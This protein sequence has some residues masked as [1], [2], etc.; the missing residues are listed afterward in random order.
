M[1]ILLRVS[2][3]LIHCYAWPGADWVE[4]VKGSTYK[5]LLIGINHYPNPYWAPLQTPV[6]DV[7]VLGNILTSRYGFKGKVDIL[8]NDQAGFL[9]IGSALERLASEVGPGD[10]VLIYFAGH[11]YLDR[12]KHGYW[13]PYDA[14]QDT[15]TWLSNYD[16]LNKYIA[17]IKARHVLLISDACFSGSLLHHRRQSNVKPDFTNLYRKKSRWAMTAGNITPVLDIASGSKHSAFAKQFL[18]ALETNKEPYITPKQIA[19]GIA[20]P[21][22]RSSGQFPQCDLIRDE[23]NEG[24]S[25]IFW[26]ADSGSPAPWL[27][28]GEVITSNKLHLL[29]G[30]NIQVLEGGDDNVCKSLEKLG[31]IVHCNPHE[32]SRH[33]RQLSYFCPDIPV[34]LG[35]DLL[36]FLGLPDY[37]LITHSGDPEL[38]DTKECG[39]EY[40]MTLWN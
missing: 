20:F 40:E 22:S 10:S 8:T 37:W 34:E 39:S 16:L 26:L 38:Y 1:K 35:K 23:N 27:N 13:I 17:G 15:E 28:K 6:N 7:T 12:Q 30:R 33:R 4:P 32:R 29:A 3:V 19:V 21:V 2:I 24:G 5:A 9:E 14:N 25:F 11:G 31:M 36:D 18:S